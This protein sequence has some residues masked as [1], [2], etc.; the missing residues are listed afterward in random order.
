MLTN[1]ILF[2]RHH[3]KWQGVLAF[4]SF[5]NRVVI[6]KSPPW[7]TMAAGTVL[8]DH[9]ETKTRTW[10][11]REDIKAAQGDVGRAIQAVAQD[12]PFNP[13]REYFDALVWDGT[14]RIDTWLQIYFHAD[15]TPYARAVGPRYLISGVAR[16]DQPGCKVDQVLVLEGPQGR[17]K[18][19]F[20]RARRQGRL[21]QR[22]ALT[23]QQQG[24]D[25]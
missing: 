25:D 3:P 6:R 8:T 2:L 18:S 1:L 22:A 11:Q 23:R 17:Q 14:P 16:I 13:V 12:A 20:A 4:N 24:C 15:D 19:G 10:F 7:G 21:V 5:A 9:L